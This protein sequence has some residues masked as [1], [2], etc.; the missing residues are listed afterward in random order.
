MG[1]SITS[2]VKVCPG[3]LC[4]VLVTVAPS[5]PVTTGWF[6][7]GGWPRLRRRRARRWACALPPAAGR[8]SPPAVRPG[9]PVPPDGHALGTR[10]G[11]HGREAGADV[12]L[13]DVGGLEDAVCTPTKPGAVDAA[14]PSVSRLILLPLDKAPRPPTTTPI[15]DA[16][17]SVVDEAGLLEH[18][19]AELG[20]AERR[21]AVAVQAHG[22][23]RARRTS[24]PRGR[25]R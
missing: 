7:Q 18:D 23:R 17:D 10:S 12:V 19:D 16:G 1:P 24:W 11:L 15:V 4:R 20:A 21:A 8:R 9:E 6:L 2:T 13:E 14:A 3:V 5:T 22:V 25:G